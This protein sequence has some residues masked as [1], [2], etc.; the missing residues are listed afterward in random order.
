M[1]NKYGIDTLYTQDGK[2]A[3]IN[4]IISGGGKDR[5]RGK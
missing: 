4:E 2:K 5:H 1:A 3:T